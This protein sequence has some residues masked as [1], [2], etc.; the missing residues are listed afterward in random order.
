MGVLGLFTIAFFAKR[1]TSA[2][3]RILAQTDLP[4]RGYPLAITIIH[5]AD[6][7]LQL[8]REGRVDAQLQAYSSAEMSRSVDT[9]NKE[10][11]GKKSSTHPDEGLDIVTG[12][13][14]PAARPFFT[15]ASQLMLLFDIHWWTSR[16]SS[17][18]DFPRIF[19]TFKRDV[20]EPAVSE[21]G[22]MLPGL[23]PRLQRLQSNNDA[24]SPTLAYVNPLDAKRT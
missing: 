22:G 7:A 6:Y 24:D 10:D 14:D 9:E 3:R 20:I 8:F 11:T 21:S 4:M 18:M 19:Q 23:E 12:D 1:H 5:I 16:P 15:L 2:G 13:D 17:L